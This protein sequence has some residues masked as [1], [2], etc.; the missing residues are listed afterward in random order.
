MKFAKTSEVRACAIVNKV[1]ISKTKVVLKQMSV[2]RT[3]VSAVQTPFVQILGD[4]ITATVKWASRAKW[5]MERTALIEMNA[6]KRTHVAEWQRVKIR[7]DRT[8]APA[9]RASLL[10]EKQS[11]ALMQT[12]A[13]MFT[14]VVLIWLVRT[15][16]DRFLALVAMDTDWTKVA[17]TA[18][19]LMN[20][21]RMPIIAPSFQSVETSSALM[22]VAVKAVTK[23]RYKELVKKFA[24][25]LAVQIHIVKRESVYV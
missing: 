6:R 20:A 2:M 10:I 11:S 24:F 8:T 22:N 9:L 25:L 15:R 19:I 3:K 16:L 14:R 17:K 12:N 18:Q 1:I 13:L 23:K 4:L 7:K 21:R 5:T